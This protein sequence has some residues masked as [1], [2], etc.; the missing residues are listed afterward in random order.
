MSAS[1][2]R[3]LITGLS[4]QD[5]ALLAA[6]LLRSG[7]DVIGTHRPGRA[8]DLWRLRE[9]GVH[10]HP[11]LQLVALDPTDAA[12]CAERVAECAPDALFH[13]AG[14]SRVA[15]SFRVPRA[16][17]A[18]NGMSTVNLREALRLHATHGEFVLASSA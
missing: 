1:N 14:Q 4:G 13:L 16:R 2:F 10:T 18:A 12:S 9:L 5:G 15:D 8:P 11:R 7:A 6:H 17:I 3:T